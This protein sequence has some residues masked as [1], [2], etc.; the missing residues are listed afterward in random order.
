LTD[1]PQQKIYAYEFDLAT[2]SISNRRI[3]VDLTAESFYPD[4]L[5]I[6]SEGCV[7][8]AMWDGWCV[9]RFS[10]E[11]KEIIRIQ[12]PVPLVTS[13][14]FGGEDLQTLYITTASIGLSQAQIENSFYSGDIFALKTAI[15][16]S[17][18][19]HFSI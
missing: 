6:D 8:S 10:P 19:Y 5:T 18:A 2:G 16:G 15:A 13:C 12:L 1:S 7:W 4:G 11:G 3:F 9:I 17:S 14:T